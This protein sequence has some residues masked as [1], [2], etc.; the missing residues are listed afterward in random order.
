MSSLAGTD[1]NYA[2]AYDVDPTPKPTIAQPIKSIQ[3]RDEPVQ[4]KNDSFIDIGR[5]AQ[6][7]PSFMTSDQKLFILSNELQKQKEH[8]EQQKKNNYFD[9][10]L[11]KKKD[12]MKLL[13]ISFIFLFA[14]SL[15]GVIDFYLKK[16]FEENILG[17]GKEFIY[18]MLYPV[19]VLLVMWNIK[20]FSK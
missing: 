11:S 16:L 20:V 17:A 3:R 15:H 8:F 12:I 5:Q 6:L 1:L 13:I 10:L 4:Q 18:R 9:K 19:T 14:L 2:F 7:D